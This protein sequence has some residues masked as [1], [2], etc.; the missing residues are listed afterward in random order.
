METNVPDEGHLV[1]MV[2]RIAITAELQ[3]KL[4]IDNPMRLY[5]ADETV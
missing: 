1:D 3:C 4:L 5:W 2:P